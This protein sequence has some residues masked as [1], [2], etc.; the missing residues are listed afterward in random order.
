MIKEYG[1][2]DF[3]VIADDNNW[4]Q[5]EAMAL[6]DSLQIKTIYVH[7]P[8]IKF[9]GSQ[10]SWTLNMKRKGLPAWN[11]I[12]FNEEKIPEVVSAIGLRDYFNRKQ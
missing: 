1:E 4:Y 9:I 5:S 12:L 10:Q 2:D 7:K 8:Y 6:L 11:I 3:R